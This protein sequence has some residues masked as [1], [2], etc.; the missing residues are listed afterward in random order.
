MDVDKARALF[1]GPIGGRLLHTEASAVAESAFVFVGSDSIVELA[2]PTVDNSRLA[3]DL[4]ENG[5]LP[6][7]CTFKV[8]DVEAAERHI[9]KVGVGVSDRSGDGF[10]L[11]PADCFGAVYAFTSRPVP[12]DPRV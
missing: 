4:A 9:D 7:G 2:K 11:E 1:E 6:H 5:E 3:V 8:V 10:T 12:G